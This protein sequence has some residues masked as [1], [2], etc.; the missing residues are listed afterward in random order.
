[1]NLI[2]KTFKFDAGHR[3]PTQHLDIKHS[4]N[5]PN[6]CRHIHGHEYKVD[7]CLTSSMLHDG[8]VMDF[9][10]LNFFKRFID[11]V[12]D[13]KFIIWVEDDLLINM[14]F[15]DNDEIMKSINK[16]KL[17][18]DTCDDGITN[19]FKLDKSENNYDDI[20]I[21]Q[22]RDISDDLNVRDLYESFVIVKF[23]PTAEELSY[24]LYK[25]I[26][27]YFEENGLSTYMI[28]SVTVHETS[29]SS[30]TYKH[31]ESINVSRVYF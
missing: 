3:V 6:K 31:K 23:I 19:K 11:K 20:L 8:M 9:N 21:L 27:N 7:V 30:A 10:N 25:Q 12:L 14:F 15:K 5:A 16:F 26:Y 28:E 2:S 22:G 29:T 4:C 18:K 1:M 17:D 24:F 13:H